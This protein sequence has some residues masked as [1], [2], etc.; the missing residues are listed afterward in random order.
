MFK[1]KARPSIW[2][3]PAFSML[4][5]VSLLAA[6]AEQA[7]VPPDREFSDTQFPEDENAQ[8][9]PPNAGAED[10]AP[11]FV[12]TP[13]AEV[14][15]LAPEPEAAPAPA[16]ARKRAGPAGTPLPT[17]DEAPTPSAEEPLG[18]GDGSGGVSCQ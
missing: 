11:A 15:G 5:F 8:A 17:L 3:K 13:E 14:P 9:P 10:D 18:S 7:A 12:P 2:M 4:V 16:A 6:C 1:Y